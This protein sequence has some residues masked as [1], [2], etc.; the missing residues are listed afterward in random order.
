MKH[1]RHKARFAPPPD[2]PEHYWDVGFPS[3]QE[4]EDRGYLNTTQARPSKSRRR[5]PLQKLFKARRDDDEET[6][7]GRKKE[8]SDVSDISD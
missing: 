1:C 2:T 8:P 5:R 7:G 4:C 6:E 3:T